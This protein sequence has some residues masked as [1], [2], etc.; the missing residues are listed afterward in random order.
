MQK[1]DGVVPPYRLRD[2]ASSDADAICLINDAQIPHVTLLPPEE[3]Q[4]LA[5]QAFRFRIAESASGDVVGFVLALDETAVYASL[6]FQWFK[7]RYSRFVYIDRIVVSPTAQGAGVGRLLYTDLA[8]AA[9]RVSPLL[10][11]E[12][13]IRPPNPGSMRFHEK[14]GF[15]QAGVQNTEDGKKTVALMTKSL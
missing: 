6:N 12:V 15:V 3:L 10:T 13:N 8:T 14:F 7:S 2:Y 9:A 5:D 4:L 11:C 1:N